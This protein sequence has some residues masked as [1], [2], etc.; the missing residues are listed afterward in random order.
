MKSIRNRRDGYALLFAQYL[1]GYMA[2]HNIHAK[3]GY[4]LA[5]ISC[6]SLLLLV[7]QSSAL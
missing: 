7:R 2:L 3:R 6:I 5:A 1:T 4:L